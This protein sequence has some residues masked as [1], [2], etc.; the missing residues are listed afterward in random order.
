[1]NNDLNQVFRSEKK[2]YIGITEYYYIKQLIQALMKPDPHMEDKGQY[3]VRSLYFDSVD[4]IDYYSKI[5][6]IE[7]R[8][9]LRLRIYDIADTAVKLEIK[10]RY[11]DYIEKESLTITKEAA[12]SVINGNYSYLETY[13]DS[14][15]VKALNIMTGKLYKPKVIVDYDREAYV[16]P[17]HNV[18]VTFDKYIR[19]AFSDRLFD[20]NIGMVPVFR[21]SVMVM[22]V[23]YDRVFP[24]FIKQAMSSA[25]I[26][27]SSIS[28]YCMVREALA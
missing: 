22:E 27:Y 6:G 7:E 19:G 5:S 26:Q 15:A 4:N 10:N 25:A 13:T 8:K 2:F 18:R 24:E 12:L 1:M 21:E 11:G 9:K 28:K 20:E 17:E 3:Y 16:Y 23:K 14:V